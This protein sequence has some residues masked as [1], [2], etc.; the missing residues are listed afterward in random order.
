MVVSSRWSRALFREGETL[1]TT[2]LLA[3]LICDVGGPGTPEQAQVVVD[4][5]MKHLE[6]S[7]GWPSGSLKGAYRNS[8]AA[9]EKFIDER[10]PALVGIDLPTYLRRR[11]AWG[12]QPLAHMGKVTAKRYHLLV[13]KGSFNKLSALAG[14]EIL[15]PLAKSTRFVE[16]VVLAKKLGEGQVELKRVRRPLK[17]LRKVG[18]SQADATLVDQAAYAYLDQLDLPAE[19]VALYSSKPMPGLTLTTTAS[20]RRT[21]K[22]EERVFKALPRLC[23]GPG[24][25]LC[26]TFSVDGFIRA[27][28]SVYRRLERQFDK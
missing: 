2:V 1:N 11:R 4:K 24:A 23:R 12:L 3:V 13:R 26:K 6:K 8:E 18:R 7:G 14:K 28:Q 17:G 10:Q 22:L 15:T 20:G 19:L 21:S 9:C 25:E 27:K 16:R 5:F